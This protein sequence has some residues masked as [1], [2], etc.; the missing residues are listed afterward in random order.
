MHKLKEMLITTYVEPALLTGQHAVSTSCLCMPA[1][2]LVFLNVPRLL[3][4]CG[5][6]I[7]KHATD[8][9]MGLAD[10][11]CVLG[12]QALGALWAADSLEE[13]RV[14]CLK[15]MHSRFPVCPLLSLLHK[16]HQCQYGIPA[17][18]VGEYETTRIACASSSMQ[19]ILLTGY[20]YSCQ[21]VHLS[22]GALAGG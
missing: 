21:V 17:A 2:K 16:Q 7:L 5:Q 3:L 22:C 11:S 13:V 12:K 4:D 19:Y 1:Q 6:A 8:C 10:A 15:M 9:G 18:P 14:C 20:L